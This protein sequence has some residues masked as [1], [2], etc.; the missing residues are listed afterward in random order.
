MKTEA[1]RIWGRNMEQ[2]ELINQSSNREADGKWLSPSGH[3][4]MKTGEKKDIFQQK[5]ELRRAVLAARDAMSLEEREQAS[6]LLADRIIGHQWFY[7]AENLLAF[8]SF[9]SEI[10]TTEILKEALCKGKRVY[11]PKVEGTQMQFYQ[12]TS[13]DELHQGYQGIREPAG[14]IKFEYQPV[15]GE[16]TLMLM[17]GAAFDSQRSR[18]GYGKGFYDRYLAERKELQLHTIAIGFAC[19]MVEN[20]PQEET[21]IR[22]YQILVQ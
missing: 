19:Q 5:K 3:A 11:L 21:D 2:K 18:L 22:P 4:F 16:K 7:R 12:I 13:L 20:I 17:P 9:G 10:D 6:Y 8:A 15:Q 14:T 1:V